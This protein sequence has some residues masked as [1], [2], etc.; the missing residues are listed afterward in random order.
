[1]GVKRGY[2]TNFTLG[3]EIGHL[4]LHFP[5][6]V[7]VREADTQ[8]RAFAQEFLLPREMMI[9]EMRRPI[10]LSNL[11]PMK[12][13]WKV[14][15]QMLIRRAFDLEFI[16]G[17]QYRYLN[18]QIRMNQWTETEPGDDLIPQPRP[19][20]MRKMAEIQYG[21]PIDLRQLSTERGIPAGL[22]AELLNVDEQKKRGRLLEFKT[23]HAD[24]ELR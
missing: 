22:L 3:E 12:S 8:A 13:R 2:R 15:L 23:K 6:T 11:A 1:L 24:Q 9:E 20:L 16:T 10:T 7:S 14:S 4:V 19:R 21:K 18:Q 17:N 5:L